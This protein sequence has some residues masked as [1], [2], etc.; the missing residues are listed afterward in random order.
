M[1]ARILEL[2]QHPH[3]KVNNIDRDCTAE[4]ICLFLAE[5]KKWNH[6]INLTSEKDEESILTQHIFDSLQ[7]SRAVEETNRVIDIGS[8]AGFPGL[9]LKF[10]YPKM[11]I[12]LVESQRKRASFLS[13]VAG[14]SGLQKI[15]V[16]N[17]R[18]EDLADKEGFSGTFDRAI[19]RSVA[20]LIDCITLGEPLLKQGG[21]IVI[22]KSPEAKI[23]ETTLTQR[24]MVLK[25]TIPIKSFSGKDSDLLV[26]EKCSTWNNSL[27]P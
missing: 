19:F 11:D 22:K 14:K 24:S 25:K 23:E 9:I 3:L 2:L 10:L 17:N 12:T 26:F 18:S 13:S 20:P 21:A 15:H 5:W 8:G 4:L 1:K 27:E 16:C 7:Y 6:K